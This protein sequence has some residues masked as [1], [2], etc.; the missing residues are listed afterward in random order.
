MD[1][2]NT[3]KDSISMKAPPCYDESTPLAGDVDI[4]VVSKSLPMTE[5]KG[6]C[7]PSK[8]HSYRGVGCR[9]HSTTCVHVCL[10]ASKIVCM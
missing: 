6:M 10:C 9:F 8:G 7:V 4:R 1:K 3:S 5:L 2:A